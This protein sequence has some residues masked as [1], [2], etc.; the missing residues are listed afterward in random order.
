VASP[1]DDVREPTT[2][3][4]PEFVFAAIGVVAGAL[5]S[6]F[7]GCEASWFQQVAACDS[8]GSALMCFA[9]FLVFVGFYL[10][11]YGLIGSEIQRLR[12]LEKSSSKNVIPRPH[13]VDR[14][15]GK[16]RG[17]TRRATVFLLVAQL[18][19]LAYLLQPNTAGGWPA[20]MA[21]RRGVRSD[22]GLLPH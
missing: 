12:M 16:I 14:S 9:G 6:V 20:R 17:F 7:L 13:F 3:D 2:P 22:S 21:S 18:C 8:P 1:E 5:L 10:S 4:A 15:Q 11:C 19:V